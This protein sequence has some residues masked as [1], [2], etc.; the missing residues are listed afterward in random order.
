MFVKRR[1]TLI[2]RLVAYTIDIAIAYLVLAIVAIISKKVYFEYGALI[3]ILLILLKD[4]VNGRSIGKRVMKLA[5]RSQF[6][7]EGDIEALTC[8]K[9]NA[10]L[11]LLPIDVITMSISRVKRRLGDL[12][13]Y[14]VVVKLSKEQPE[15]YQNQLENI[16]DSLTSENYIGQ[17]KI[18]KLASGFLIF[19]VVLVVGVGVAFKTSGA[20]KASI[21]IIET[22]QTVA[23]LVGDIEG[24]GIFPTGKLTTST[25]GGRARLVITINGEKDSIKVQAVSYKNP[26]GEWVVSELRRVAD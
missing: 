6:D 24:Y 8:I 19:I 4:S 5:V 20:Y 2:E 9:R 11:L 12:K 26:E 17:S 25:T 1:A 23:E 3:I 18:I 7:L 22:N 10:F 13:T 14:T 15:D 16:K 21:E